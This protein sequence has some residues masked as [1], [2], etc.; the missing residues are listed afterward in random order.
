MRV[1][2][3]GQNYCAINIGLKSLLFRISVLYIFNEL[4]ANQASS[5]AEA[6]GIS[7]SRIKIIPY[8]GECIWYGFQNERGAQSFL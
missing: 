6:H 7:Q 5:C 1:M 4:I 3:W 2:E 8:P